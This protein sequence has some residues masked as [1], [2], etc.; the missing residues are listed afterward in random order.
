MSDEER[1]RVLQMVATG[2]ISPEEADDVLAALA[3]GREPP[4]RRVA[5]PAPVSKEAQRILRIEISDGEKNVTVRIPD[6]LS[7]EQQRSLAGPAKEYLE[8]YDIQLEPLLNLLGSLS[9]GTELVDVS[10]DEHHIGIQVE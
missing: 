2:T 9:R 5:A 7:P 3:A 1:V 4:P 10:E 6:G 8:G